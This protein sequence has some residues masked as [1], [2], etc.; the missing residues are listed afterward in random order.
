[1][2][3]LDHVPN[4]RQTELS[5]SP[6]EHPEDTLESIERAVRRIDIILATNRRDETIAIPTQELVD[7]INSLSKLFFTYDNMVKMCSTIGMMNE[8]DILNALEEA[9]S[10]IAAKY[11][12]DRDERIILAAA[13]LHLIDG[14][15]TE[16]SRF[17]A[18]KLARSVITSF[19]EEPVI[20]EPVGSDYFRSLAEDHLLENA[21]IKESR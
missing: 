7:I 4:L 15:P 8:E 18:R 12:H 16:K 14:E 6:D 1:M 2:A 19:D 9:E 5:L 21:Q 11:E 3:S 17:L 20:D 10:I 13:V